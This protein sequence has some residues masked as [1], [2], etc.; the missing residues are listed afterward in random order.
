MYYGCRSV[1][2]L[3]IN[4]FD[5]IAEASENFEAYVEERNIFIVMSTLNSSQG[6]IVPFICKK[7][8]DF[9]SPIS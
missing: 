5:L 2:S 1:L 9:G 7:F 8:G 3:S 4:F 6:I